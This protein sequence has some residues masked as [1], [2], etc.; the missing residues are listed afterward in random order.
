VVELFALLT[1]MTLPTGRWLGLD[2]I[3]SRIWPFRK[4]ES[5]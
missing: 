3:L 4:K 2:A 1:L 5:T